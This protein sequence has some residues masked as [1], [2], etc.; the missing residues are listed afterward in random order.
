MKEGTLRMKVGLIRL[1]AHLVLALFAAVAMCGAAAAPEGATMVAFPAA[2]T[3]ASASSTVMALPTRGHPGVNGN[4]W[5]YNYNSGNLIYHPATRICRYFRCIPS[6]WR[7]TR[8][9]VMQCRDG[10]ISH[11]GGRSGSCSSHGGNKR[12]LY[13]R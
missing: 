5:G 11:S 10:T 7:Q 12:P 2:I 6:F 13:Q 1:A 8:G 9:Y 3:Q 4:P